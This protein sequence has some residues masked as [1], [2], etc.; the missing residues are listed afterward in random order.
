M[1]LNY[2]TITTYK[3]VDFAQWQITE[4]AGL[5][6]PDEGYTINDIYWYVERPTAQKMWSRSFMEEAIKSENFV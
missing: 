6:S 4:E 2:K 1:N 5:D 3:P